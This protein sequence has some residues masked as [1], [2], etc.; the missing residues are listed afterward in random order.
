MKFLI[1]EAFTGEPFGGNTAGIVI[2]PDGEEFPSETIMMKTAAELRYSETAFIK[3]LGKDS[4]QLRY[5]T[6]AAEVDLCGHATIASFGALL[7]LGLIRGESICDCRTKSGDLTITLRNGTVMMEMQAPLVAG[8]IEGRGEL[9]E[10]YEAMGARIPEEKALRPAIVTAGIPDILLPVCCRHELHAME[11]DMKKL[12]ELSERYG[13]TGVHAFTMDAEEGALC[14]CRNFAPLFG[15]DE[16]AATGTS[17]AGLTWYLK[18]CGIIGED[19]QQ[20]MI[21]GESMGRRSVIRTSVQRNKKTGLPSICVGGRTCI[22]AEGEIH[23]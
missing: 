12:A 22:L 11:P 15:I 1:A 21:Q 16:E 5:F 18:E 13:V 7:H 9:E 8:M 10:L 19:S 20:L 23:I 6:P 3:T 4:F 14:H 17:S 2:L